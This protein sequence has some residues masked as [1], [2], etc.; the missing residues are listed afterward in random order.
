MITNKQPF[1]M[2]F[3][4]VGGQGNV[5]A[6]K[7]TALAAVD[8]GLRVNV[9]EPFGASQR[10]GTVM[11][12]VRVYQGDRTLGPLI[13]SGQAHLIIGFEPLDTLRILLAYGNRETTVIVNNRP[14]YPLNV[15]AGEADYPNVEEI[16]K[17]MGGMVEDL[18][19]IQAT[20]L[21]FKAG[22]ALSTNIVMVGALAGL[23]C[24]PITAEL[25]ENCISGFFRPQHRELN[26][27]AFRLGL[28]AVSN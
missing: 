24:L 19:V 1:N 25:F 8:A 10:G 6:S 11:S 22:S 7:L 17:T 21:A 16:M 26:I 2:I 4:G 9:G 12:H 14:V 20:D 23:K 3:A 5:I 28:Q 13:P 15:L 27:T 18:R